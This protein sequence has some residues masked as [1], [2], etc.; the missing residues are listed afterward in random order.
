MSNYYVLAVRQP[1]LD[2]LIQKTK[3]IEVRTRIP[4][5]LKKGDWLFLVETGTH[6]KIQ[7]AAQIKRIICKHPFEFWADYHET[8]GIT[9]EDF[10][11]YT[12][13]RNLIFGLQLSPVTDGRKGRDYISKLGLKRTPQWFQR[14]DMKKVIENLYA[15]RNNS[16]P[17]PVEKL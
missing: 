12:S 9:L 17:K 7:S 15:K 6:G 5:E 2:R 14:I 4:T 13:G 16:T 11:K 3:T 1:Y 8:L 10:K